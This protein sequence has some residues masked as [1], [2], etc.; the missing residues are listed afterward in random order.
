MLLVKRISQRLLSEQTRWFLWTPIVLMLGISFYFWLSSEPSL[1]ALL[2]IVEAFLFLLYIYRQNGPLF[3]IFL[4]LFIFT[5]GTFNAK[6]HTHFIAK[7]VSMIEEKETT[8]LKG[9]L[10]KIDYNNKGRMRLWLDDVSD[11]D[12]KR[13]GYYRVTVPSKEDKF[14]LG[15][16]V[17]LVATLMP[18]SSA[19]YPDGFEFDRHAFYQGISATGYAESNVFETDCS[20]TPHFT[21]RIKESVAIA[22][23][24]ISKY[25][26]KHLSPEQSA[27]ASA[28]LVGDK[29]H[30]EEP[31][32]KQYRDS[33]L[34]HFLAISGLHM[35][36]VT[37]FAFCLIRLLMAFFP[38]LALNFSSKKIASVVAIVFGLIYLIIS[39][40]SVSALRAFIMTSLVFLGFIFDRQPISMRTV[41]IAALVVL[42]IEPQ[43][44]LTASFQMSFA[45][46]AG[47]IDFYEAH[48]HRFHF[49][50]PKPTHYVFYY[51]IGVLIASIVAT[52]AT[53]P[54]TFYHFGT[55]APYTLL[56][57]FFAAPVIAFLVMPFIFLALLLIPFHLAL[58][59]LK[60]VGLG[61]SLLN[62]ITTFVSGLPH[63][64]L[65]VPQMPMWAFFL[66]IFGGL[67]LTLW[68]RRWRLYG[69]V[70]IAVGLLGFC[71][72]RSPDVLYTSDGKTIGIKAQ[73]NH[74]FVFSHKQNKFVQSIWGRKYKGVI[75]SQSLKSIDAISLECKK[76]SCTY[77]GLFEFDLD[78]HLKFYRQPIDYVSDKGGAIYFYGGG[79]K[80]KEIRKAVGYRPWNTIKAA[81]TKDL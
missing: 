27:I 10:F 38:F 43:V 63:A 56:G 65:S 72:V 52:A 48:G 59:P 37:M 62:K 69:L 47:L 45:A 17:E 26:S 67:W 34:A 60:V 31:L 8:Y 53:M 20:Y 44:L 35:G 33:G 58:L 21:D 19:L 77:L 46:A 42:M 12:N 23:E 64:D 32:Y 6:L 1:I 57:N 15:T 54:F 74:L 41:A 4:T 61:I 22:R 36:F 51:F 70:F 3:F 25:I 14:N 81:Q 16:C 55:F 18:P 66:I 9:H 75:P 49:N 2:L 79:A 24:K 71:F 39:G 29:S 30:I 28:I 68:R 11:Y 13:E 40:F 50:K 5:L 80:K 78:G 7:H 73:N 76:G